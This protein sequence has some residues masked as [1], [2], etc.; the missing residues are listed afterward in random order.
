M[1]ATV[2]ELAQMLISSWV[3]VRPQAPLP[4]SEGILDAALLECVGRGEFPKWFRDRLRF[5]NDVSGVRCIELAA[6]LEEAQA[7][8]LTE[9]PNPTYTRTV[10][11]ATPFMAESMAFELDVAVEDVQSWGRSLVDAVDRQILAHD[12]H[13]IGMSS[14]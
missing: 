5:S 4:T 6:I 11:R 7:S 13:A 2:N 10:V 8:K 3:M 14:V 9:A 12:S 1:D